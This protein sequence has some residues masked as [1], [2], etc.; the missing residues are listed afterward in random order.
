MMLFPGPSA[1]VF[2]LITKV[3]QS[4]T[5]S[6]VSRVPDSTNI[7]LTVTV[8]YTGEC[9]HIISGYLKCIKLNRGTNDEACRK[10]AKQYLACRMDKYVDP[11]HHRTGYGTACLEE[12]DGK[13]ETLIRAICYLN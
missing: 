5:P 6:A 1:V 10:L 11:L 8:Y 13:N 2:L 4:A 12:D 3:C 7:G 9:K